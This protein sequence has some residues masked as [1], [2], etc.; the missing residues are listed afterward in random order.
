MLQGDGLRGNKDDATRTAI[1][2]AGREEYQ[3]ELVLRNE[4]ASNP[5]G[6]GTKGANTCI[7]ESLPSLADSGEHVGASNVSI[8][9][10]EFISIKSAVPK[11]SAFPEHYVTCLE[12]TV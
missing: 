10:R 11:F 6:E 1:S 2:R 3:T 12:Q 7:G 4:T 5:G 9:P 8:A